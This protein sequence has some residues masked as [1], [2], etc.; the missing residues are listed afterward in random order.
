MPLSPIR[1]EGVRKRF[2]TYDLEWYPDTY[3]TRLVGCYDGEQYD[4]YEGR[5][6]IKSFLNAEL[7]PENS[8]TVY[9]AH[10]GGLADVQ[11]IL[12]EV[13]KPE[14]SRGV[15]IEA[16][17]SGSS[18]IIVQ[19]ERAGSVWTFADSY[20][21]LKDRL[22]K[23]GDSLGQ[24][25]L[26]DYVCPGSFEITRADG[27]P[28]TERSCGHRIRRDSPTCIFWAPMP[29]LK[30][31]NEMDNKILWLGINRLQDELLELGGELKMTVASCAM[32]LFRGRF[33]QREIKTSAKVNRCAREAYVASRVEVFKHKIDRQI[34]PAARE[35]ARALLEQLDYPD[36]AWSSPCVCEQ[37]TIYTEPPCPR[38]R[39]KK[40]EC[41]DC[42]L[43][44]K[45]CV[46]CGNYPLSGF[47]LDLNSSFPS[48]LTKP[49]PGNFRGFKKKWTDTDRLAIVRCEVEVPESVNIPPI[50]VREKGRV[51][52]PVGRWWGWYSGVDLQLLLEKGGKIHHVYGAMTF[53]PFDDL[54]G[55]VEVLYAMRAK[56][57]DP[58]RKLLLK[59]L[60]NT[61]YGKFA[62]GA[63][64][65]TLYV[66]KPLPRGIRPEDA[67]ELGPNTWLFDRS[68]AVPH[69]HVPISCITTA[70]SRELIARPIY[71]A[72][73][74][75]YTDTDSLTSS[76]PLWVPPK[77][78]QEGLAGLGKL[79]VE[80]T[81]KGD[82]YFAFPKFY[83]IDEKVK[84]KGFSPRSGDALTR[85][86]FE[87]LLKGGTFEVGRMLRVRELAR[88]GR[89]TPREKLIGKRLLKVSRPKRKTLE[90]EDNTRPWHFRELQ[91]PYKKP[92]RE[93]EDG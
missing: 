10:A 64:K 15:Q 54:R 56:E 4:G 81:V 25:K 83:R 26:N 78:D 65:Q 9:F 66:H 93:M 85:E 79:K 71:E 84:A 24:K 12:E 67:E 49:Q 60:L 89:M 86:E 44:K 87:H 57:K 11:F 20:W 35:R 28:A 69:E 80:E 58:F 88:S 3:V 29:I 43:R 23:I 34:S 46:E 47:Y 17:F 38:C 53:E 92:K 27:K 22:E 68:V 40:K 70:L 1:K 42:K 90:D 18:A 72:D 73:E 41:D 74:P 6:G 91:E 45:R 30:T 51:Y 77:S 21:L 61:C 5:D 50:P 76:S 7:V 75:N 59:Y 48:S 39:E 62:E 82:A 16:A 36:D 31:Y 37:P 63:L 55:Y 33:L 14:H 8:G 52:F 32:R 13:W 19:V 2:K